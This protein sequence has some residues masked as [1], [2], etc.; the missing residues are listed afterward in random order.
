MMSWS[1]LK[2]KSCPY[3][4]DAV[5]ERFYTGKTIKHSALCHFGTD[6]VTQD[7]SAWFNHYNARQIIEAGIKESIQVFYLH[8]IK[9][10]S[11]PAIFLQERMALFAANFIRWAT[12]WLAVQGQLQENA[13]DIRNMGVKRQ[14]QVSAHVSAQVI[15]NSE[16]MLLKFSE[17]SAFSGKALSLPGGGHPPLTKHRF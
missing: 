15:R 5:L 7:L 13:L 8:R 1:D 11:E 16:G 6:P 2:L 9:V 3:L 12:H 10:R 4:L 17:H 14:V